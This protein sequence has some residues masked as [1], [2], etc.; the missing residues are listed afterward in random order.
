MPPMQQ[1]RKTKMACVLPHKLKTVPECLRARYQPKGDYNWRRCH[2]GCDITLEA[3]SHCRQHHTRGEVTLQATCHRKLQH[4]SCQLFFF[5]GG[6]H[7]ATSEAK[8]ASARPKSEFLFTTI[9]A[10]L[11][12]AGQP[13]ATVCRLG[14]FR[15]TRRGVPVLE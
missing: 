6:G 14:H 7:Q 2:T 15:G 3:T 11:T 4:T 5:N 13:R 1:T 10:S 8:Y 12:N 9:P